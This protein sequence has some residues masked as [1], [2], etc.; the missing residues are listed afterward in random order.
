M[1]IEKSLN[2]RVLIKIQIALLFI[3]R[4]I[5]GYIGFQ[6]IVYLND[7]VTIVMLLFLIIESDLKIVDNLTKLIF[8]EIIYW[9]ISFVLGAN[10]NLGS[11]IYMLRQYGRFYI[12]II[13]VQKCYREQEYLKILSFINKLFF[14]HFILTI[15]QVFVFKIDLDACGGIFG[16]VYG[17]GNIANHTLLLVTMII[18]L[19][20]YF[21]KKESNY[22]FFL[23]T[24]MILSLAVII[25]IK[26]F[27]FEMM[28]V[29]LIFIL[30]QKKINAKTIIFVIIAFCAMVW[31]INYYINNFG[32]D[33][34]DTQGITLYLSNGYAGNIRGIGRTDG[35][36]KI[37]KNCFDN[38]ILRSLF[39]FG[40]G[41]SS[42]NSLYYKFGDLNL[43]YFTYAKLFYDMGIIGVILYYLP[44]IYIL[45]SGIRKIKENTNFSLLSIMATITA[46]YMTFYGTVMESD[47]GGYLLYFM[48]GGSYILA[49]SYKRG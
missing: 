48:M 3:T 16:N 18:S 15:L 4:F 1:R 36:S 24:V 21:D 32:F 19:Y 37:I 42:M 26:S 46:I 40:L 49:K 9:M 22:L 14:L 7:V 31:G 28:F 6:E 23:K 20:Y 33:I 38:S 10:N 41:A 5:S 25:E 39:G 35:F 43:E 17:Y 45:I 29:Y 34:F 13:A 47:I 12:F 30:V 8:V 44:Y 27:I 11:L 2:M